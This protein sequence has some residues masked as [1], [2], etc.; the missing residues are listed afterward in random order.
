MAGVTRP[1]ARFVGGFSV[2]EGVPDS[3]TIASTSDQAL[4]VS[5][6]RDFARAELLDRDRQW[7]QG[8]GS[9]TDVLPM[10]AEMGFLNIISPVD[11][12]GLGCDYRTYASILHEIS[13]AS[14]STAVTLSVHTMV[15]HV[16]NEFAPLEKRAEW[17]EGWGAVEN[18]GAFAISEA[19]A[20]SDPSAV[21]TRATRRG[22]QYVLNGEKMWIS[23]GLSAKW[24]ATLARTTP[25]TG[26]SGLSMIMVDG[27]TKGV[28]RTAMHGKM[29]IRGSETAVI[30]FDDVEVPCD[31]LLGEE[32]RGLAV[33]LTALNGGRIGIAAQ[34]T[35]IAEA[36]L[37]EMLVF[38]P[39]REQFGRKIASFQAVQNMIADSAVELAAAK[40]LVHYAAGLMDAE[41]PDPSAVAKAKLFASESA[42]RIAYRAVQVHG[43]MGYVNDCR[44]EQLYRDARVTTIY[45]GTSEIQRIVIARGLFP[46][47]GRD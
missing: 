32:G 13:Y 31:N 7:D 24:F 3:V 47:V 38:A 41:V 45:E 19:G 29:G 28:Q 12:G 15:G 21:R 42:N 1:G 4:L 6:A 36:C 46:D 35:G 27:S 9:V 37:D 14:P 5:A 10:L 8:R 17:L 25:G 43:G 11:T 16:L 18:F 40:E 34:A 33:S 30:A 44:V 22:D 20:G 26:K 39:E 23:N 2:H